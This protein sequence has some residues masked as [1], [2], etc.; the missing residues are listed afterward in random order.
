MTF[1]AHHYCEAPTG[2]GGCARADACEVTV[3]FVVVW[4]CGVVQWSAN[5]RF[6][7]NATLAVLNRNLPAVD[8]QVDMQGGWCVITVQPLAPPMLLLASR[9]PHTFLWLVADRASYVRM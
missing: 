6:Q 3:G 5:G 4:C 2:K 1:G 8:H 9:A 7:N